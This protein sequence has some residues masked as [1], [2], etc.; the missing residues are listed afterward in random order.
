MAMKLLTRENLRYALALIAVVLIAVLVWRQLF[1]CNEKTTVVINPSP[2]QNVQ[3]EN[4]EMLNDDGYKAAH[5]TDEMLKQHKLEGPRCG[6]TEGE[7]MGYKYQIPEELPSAESLMPEETACDSYYDPEAA[8]D[9]PYVFTYPLTGAITKTRIEQAGDIWRG[10]LNIPA[11]DPNCDFK[12]IWNQGD[13][14]LHGAFANYTYKSQELAGCDNK[15]VWV[16]NAPINVA[17]EE[18]IQ[19]Y[20]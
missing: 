2:S 20:A 19:D 16:R 8:Q 4:Y 7:M 15:E 14:L 17:N 5:A 1:S 3:K 13:Q 6:I 18:L 11:R 10:D 9:V 12:T